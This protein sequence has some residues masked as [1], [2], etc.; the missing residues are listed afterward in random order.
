MSAIKDDLTKAVQAH[1]TAAGTPM[2]KAATEAT[3]DAVL[4]G[5]LDVCQEKETIRTKI[6][7]FRWAHTETR[8]RINPRNQ[9]PV[10]VEAYSTLKFR[11]SKQVRV[12]DSSKK[13]VKKA[14]VKAA[15]AAVKA[16]PAK[17]AAKPAMKKVIKK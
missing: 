17:V 1:L 5:I 16:A 6:G 8:E 9:E 13:P 11:P 14:A 3:I 4:S 10:T 7:I 2:Q 12:L 15:P